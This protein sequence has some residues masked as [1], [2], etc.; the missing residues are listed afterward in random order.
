[1]E[2]S[3]WLMMVQGSNIT[4]NQNCNLQKQKTNL[5]SLVYTQKVL[6]IPMQKRDTTGTKNRARCI[7]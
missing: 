6:T 7:L 2:T 3:E 4:F 5:L 1:M